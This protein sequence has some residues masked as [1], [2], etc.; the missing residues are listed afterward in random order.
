MSTDYTDFH[1]LYRYKEIKKDWPQITQI[2]TDYLELKKLLKIVHRLCPVE[3][4]Y[5]RLFKYKEIK[6]DCPQIAQ[7]ST[8][9]F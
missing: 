3:T 9:Y 2:S 4:D 8:D 1:R 5:H 7:I 6:K